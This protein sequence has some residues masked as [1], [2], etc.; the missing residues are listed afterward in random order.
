MTTTTDSIAADGACSLREAVIAAN[1]DQATFDCPAGSGADVIGFSPAI[2]RPAT[3]V[4]DRTGPG[5]DASQTGDLDVLGGLTISGDGPALIV[6]DGA[7]GDRAF[8]ARP[9]ARLTLAGAGVRGGAAS[10]DA[11]GGVLVR[12]TAALTLTN[13]AVTANIGGGAVVLGQLHAT[14]SSFDGNAGGGLLIDGGAATLVDVK[15]ADNTGG[16]GILSRNLATLSYDGGA[17]RNNAAGGV[18]NEGS[19]ATLT[20]LQIRDN[21]GS[22]I[23][24]AGAV[25]TSLDLSLSTLAG[26]HAE[27]GAGLSNM[28]TGA[29]AS[30]ITTT[31]AGNVATGA[32]GAIYNNGALGLAASLLAGNSARTGG[33]LDHASGNLR[34]ANDTFSGNRASDDG[35]GLYNRASAVLEYVTFADNSASGPGTGAQLFNDTALLSLKA[36][37][38]DGVAGN[39]TNSGG[40]VTSL[41]H[42]L[43]TGNSCGLTGPGDLVNTSSGLERLAANGGPTLTHAAGPQPALPWTRPDLQAARQP[44]K[45]HGAAAGAGLRHRRV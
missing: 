3:F 28:G 27:Q 24:N 15:V 40:T 29:L 41:G 13:V 35:G 31:F 32:G 8:D 21:G 14:G 25:L 9:G 22:G 33:G 42:N 20:R 5:E 6:V 12:P 39:C 7:Y 16:F 4:L 18:A 37:L 34:L 30:V 44:T 19:R 10:P 11:G 23:L 38:I 36:T 1:T 17:V 45:R 43:E 2:P 26:N